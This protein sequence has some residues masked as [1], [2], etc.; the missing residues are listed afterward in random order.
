VGERGKPASSGVRVLFGIGLVLVWGALIAVALEVIARAGFRHVDRTNPLVVA[1]RETLEAY[2][3][4]EQT[5]WDVPYVAYRA[6]AELT[7]ER[8]DEYYHVTTNSR[9]WR[10]PE[11]TLPKPSGVFRI[12]CVGGSTTV[13]GWTDDTTYPAFL[14]EELNRRFA[15]RLAIDVVNAGVSGLASDGELKKADDYL[16]LQPDLVVEYN[17]VNDLAWRL[18]PA[19]RAEAGAWQ[20]LLRRSEFV[21]TRFPGWIAPPEKAV[22]EQLRGTTLAN[23]DRL[24]HRMRDAGADFAVASFAFPDVAKVDEERREFLDHN[25]VTYWGL[26][27]TSYAGYQRA[28]GWYNRELKAL[29]QTEGFLYLPVAERFVDQEQ[30]FIDIC[31]LDEEGMRIKAQIFAEALEPYLRQKA[32]P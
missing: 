19:L 14:E 21:R 9:G 17:V 8:G 4:Q 1:F 16:A 31:H 24:G 30:H 12:V 13:S 11:V 15:G 27:E 2:D 20:R 7:V 26:R 3:E 18:Y 28:V 6:N 25:A 29:A 10:G 23:L 32:A 5:L 22:V